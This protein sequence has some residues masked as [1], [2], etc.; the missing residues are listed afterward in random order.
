M[1]SHRGGRLGWEWEQQP[2]LF[3]D[4]LALAND[5]WFLIVGNMNQEQF[6]WKISDLG[7]DR[8]ES[9]FWF[10]GLGRAAVQ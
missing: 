4:P 2:W 9:D 5:G 3:L 8:N 7:W 6:E 10:M 1:Q